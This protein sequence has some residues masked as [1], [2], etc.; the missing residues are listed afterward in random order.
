MSPIKQTK[1]TLFQ[2]NYNVKTMLALYVPLDL[3]YAIEVVYI[4]QIISD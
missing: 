4:Y 2:C 3:T 1:L